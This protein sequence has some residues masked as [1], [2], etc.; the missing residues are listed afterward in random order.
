M[1]SSKYSLSDLSAR[2]ELELR[3]DGDCMIDGVGT[4]KSAGP[5][6]ITFLANPAYRADPGSYTARWRSTVAALPGAV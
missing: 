1:T 4:L 5:E 2:F 3:G 6:Q